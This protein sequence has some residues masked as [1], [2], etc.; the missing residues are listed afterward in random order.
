VNWLVLAMAHQRLGHADEARKWF[1]KAARW[2]DNYGRGAPG[3][4]EALRSLHPHDALACLVLRRE[5]EAL[6]G[7]RPRP[8][9]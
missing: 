4:A 3:P 7:L 9:R 5:A 8:A 2:M 6:L 1:D